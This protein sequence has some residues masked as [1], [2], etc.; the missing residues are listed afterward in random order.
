MS[1]LLPERV[2]RPF[3][4]RTLRLY[5]TVLAAGLTILGAGAII[6][7]ASLK[8]TNTGIE[9]TGDNNQISFDVPR[10]PGEV[11]AATIAC[12]GIVEEVKRE[13]AVI[14]F[15]A[16]VTYR[17][18]QGISTFYSL[19]LTLDENNKPLDQFS[20]YIEQPPV[21]SA[22]DLLDGETD[23]RYAHTEFLPVDA[24]ALDCL[25]AGKR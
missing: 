21:D 9:V 7:L 20:V 17:D 10:A 18:A 4:G 16:R 11:T 6:N 8:L 25:T 1:R 3:N 12:D 23:G 2:V 13:T 22:Q 19:V 14:G 5:L 24:V 15:K